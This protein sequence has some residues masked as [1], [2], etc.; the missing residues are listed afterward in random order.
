MTDSARP[1]RDDAGPTPSRSSDTLTTLLLA[2][3]FVALLVAAIPTAF[4]AAGIL[5]T[6]TVVPVVELGGASD[7]P[8]R[9]RFDE[10]DE[11]R[12]GAHSTR[13]PSPAAEDEDGDPLAGLRMGSVLR[14]THVV[15]RPESGAASTGDLSA[16]DLVR[17][18]QESG[19]WAL[20]VRM[21]REPVMGWAKTSDLA[22]R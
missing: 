2:G 14:P 16:G 18:V 3:T 5:R 10:P 20:V 19:D 22:V 17:I 12:V 6:T 7:D 21:E 1:S 8:H 15:E 11:P 13:A 4:R 9:I